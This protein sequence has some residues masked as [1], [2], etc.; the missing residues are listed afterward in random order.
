MSLISLPKVTLAW[1][2]Q[3]HSLKPGQ[4]PE[5]WTLDSGPWILD[6]RL[7]NVDFLKPFNLKWVIK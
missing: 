3:G 1:F 4:D 5:M 2:R 7:W 6:S